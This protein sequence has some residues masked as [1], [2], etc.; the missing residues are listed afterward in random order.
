MLQLQCALLEKQELAAQN[1]RL[2]NEPV[3]DTEAE[4]ACCC[5]DNEWLEAWLAEMKQ[6][7]KQ[8]LW[9]MQTERVTGEVYSEATVTDF[10]QELDWQNT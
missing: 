3:L 5:T 1:S 6:L 9:D 8:L 10:H 2:W 7:Y 4:L